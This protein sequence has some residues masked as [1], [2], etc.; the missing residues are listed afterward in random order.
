MQ[1][2]I[3]V[4]FEKKHKY[5]NEIYD[6]LHP[7][8]NKE[9]RSYINPKQDF[10]FTFRDNKLHYSKD[11]EITINQNSLSKFK[12]FDDSDLNLGKKSIQNKISYNLSNNLVPVILISYF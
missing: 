8:N 5:F 2:S 7:Q 1:Q 12:T 10:D 6:D 4:N 9:K 11:K 3:S